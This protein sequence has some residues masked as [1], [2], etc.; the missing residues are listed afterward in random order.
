MKNLL[1]LLAIILVTSCTTTN[2]SNLDL[3]KIQESNP[4]I[5]ELS[6]GTVFEKEVLK[7]QPHS[8]SQN[9]VIWEGNDA[10]IWEDA[11]YLVCEI[12]H[13]NDF[14]G[15]INLEFFRNEKAGETIV[16]Q[17]GEE[18]GN[19]AETPRMAAKIGVLPKLKTKLIFPLEHL[20]GQEIFMP[21]FPRQL[22][23]TVLGNRMKPE[24]ISKVAINFAPWMEPYFMP[25]FEVAAV[26][27]TK[28]VPQPFPDLESPIVDSL[29]QWT[30]RDW[31]GKTKSKAE[32]KNLLEEQ[33]NSASSS[34]FPENWSKYGG[35]K[36]KQFE[37]TGFFRTHH[38][39]NRWWLVDPEGYAFVSVGVDCI[40]N[41]AT[42]M[43]SG[44]E[45][46]FEWLPD[47][48][49]AVFKDAYSRRGD[50]VQVDF[51]KTNL[52]RVFGENWRENWETITSGQIREFRLNT[53]GNWS[54]IEYA[55]K[56]QI[57]YVLPLG[58]FPSTEIKLFRDFPDVF[59]EEYL[60]NA[61][62]YAQQLSE[63]KND[64]YLIGYFLR[65]EPHWAF[66]AHDIAYE[67]FATEQPSES[68]NMFAKWLSQRYK[69]IDDL[70]DKWGIEFESFE[71][72]TGHIF[73]DYPSAIAKEDFWLFSE[74]LV[75]KYVDVPCDE[76]EKIDPN[77]LN[78]GMRYAWISSDLLYKA[79][80]RF[81]VF[82]INGYGNPG[83]PETAEIAE[84]S[85]K[86][87]MIGEFHFGA[88]D[89]GLPAT[90][91]QGALNQEARGKAYRYYLEQG[92]AR[93]E[94]IGIHYF[95][96]LDQPVF[97]RF[98]GEN[99]N[100]GFMDICNRPYKELTNAAIESHSKMYEI[101]DGQEAP[102]DEVIQKI[103]SIHY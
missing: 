34:S 69:S 93:P 102:F 53:I 25:E 91:I 12:W 14:S 6:P 64:P 87:V 76:V 65:N 85:G 61:Q 22:K 16:A 24:E 1:L 55:Q 13:A 36:E 23:G 17:S 81:D 90:G 9:L 66:G 32:L 74:I 3:L 95:Q 92:L 73:E 21:R 47:S 52:T 70:S 67:M 75:K 37:A 57:P 98:D 10:S 60:Q 49:D 78:L 43:I 18:S 50:Q 86:P 42:G 101:A 40:R 20:N 88:I 94:L 77:H 84:I 99:Y 35:W 54:D 45:D 72:I 29:G 30:A 8:E 41:N 27:L 80:D 97:G 71:A 2:K 44:Q 19:E 39:G 38:D 79:G 63:F 58:G 48:T 4:K 83:P 89:R 82:S 51:Y 26:Y 15:V 59:S 68:K 28:E 56:A 31:P 103:P 46:L 5:S 96:W 7:I 62:R 100:I 11:N 33:L